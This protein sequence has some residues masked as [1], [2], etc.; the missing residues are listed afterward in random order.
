MANSSIYDKKPSVFQRYIALT[1]QKQLLI[2]KVCKRILLNNK[3]KKLSLTDI[4][5]ADGMVTLQIINELK[6]IFLLDT[7]VIE[8]STSLINDFKS[9]TNLN[10]NFINEDI[11]FVNALPKSDFILMSHIVSYINNLEKFLKKAFD[12]LSEKGIAL[13][14]VSNDHSD[15][16]MTSV[17]K[18]NKNQILEKIKLIL[19]SNHVRYDI[20]IVEST[21]DVSG[22]YDMNDD[23]KTLIEFFKHKDINDISHDEIEK[24]RKEILAIANENKKI[25]KKENYIWFYK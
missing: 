7:T 19:T 15:D 12:S 21:I 1:N 23:G 2:D 11:E 25:I 24:M 3:S 4:G 20:E 8:K 5:C 9:K 18:N 17:E 13:I 16:V 22:I 10:I 6:K 14:V